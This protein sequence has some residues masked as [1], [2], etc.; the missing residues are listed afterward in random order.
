LEH[1]G[2]TL[3]WF[4]FD[5][6]D[7]IDAVTELAWIDSSGKTGGLKFIEL[8]DEAREQISGWMRLHTMAKQA[9]RKYKSVR[10]P[11]STVREQAGTG[12]LLLDDIGTRCHSS[13]VQLNA[14]SFHTTQLVPV[15]QHQSALRRQFIRG[16]L[17]GAIL[18][19]LVATA[20]VKFAHHHKQ[21]E[22]A[23]QTDS[24]QV[25]EANLATTG[26][27]TS[28]LMDSERTGRSN[29]EGAGMVKSRTSSNSDI[30]NPLNARTT[31]HPLQSPER[32]PIPQ[33]VLVPIKSLPQS[34]TNSRKSMSTPAQLWTAVQAGND[35]AAVVLA[36][37][38]LQGEGVPV[39][40][41]QAKVLL[42][43]AAAKHNIQATA[44]LRQLDKTGCPGP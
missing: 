41:D 6:H 15:E 37:R 11:I 2:K 10:A 35:Q 30:D 1:N 34:A 21:Q 39:N 43:V 3:C 32:R 9:V 44:R 12:A 40:C 36:N 20:V 8:S 16:V 25:T 27:N 22:V 19:S 18:S 24:K 31:G 14:T 33:E 28:S 5:L 42:Q 26:G 29:I 17:L 7:R 38:Y 23:L 13:E 4:S